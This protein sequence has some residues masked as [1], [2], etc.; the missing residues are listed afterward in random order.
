MSRRCGSKLT[1][2]L[3]RHSLTVHLTRH[4]PYPPAADRLTLTFYREP[5]TSAAAY[6]LPLTGYRLPPTVYRLPSTVYLQPPDVHCPPPLSY[7]VAES[8]PA[9]AEPQEPDACSSFGRSPQ[10]LTETDSNL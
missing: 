2:T 10:L 4:R 8:A 6:R 1:N 5:S 9:S 3:I 7:T